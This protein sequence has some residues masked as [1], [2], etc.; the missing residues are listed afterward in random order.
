MALFG[1]STKIAYIGATNG[2]I[3]DGESTKDRIGSITICRQLR[4]ARKKKNIKGII[5][6]LDTP[7]GSATAC[8][9]M[10]CEIKECINASKPVI[11]V[12]SNVAA[13]G[14]Y[15]LSAPCS[16][17]FAS[18]STITGSI[19]IIGI[20]FT[21]KKFWKNKLGVN[22]DRVSTNPL[23]ASFFSQLDG[24][25]EYERIRMEQALTLWYKRFKG[26]ISE[27]RDMEDEKL[28]SVAKGQ[29]WLGT[30][31]LEIGLVDELGG[32][33]DAMK[34]MKE[35]LNIPSYKKIKLVNPLGKM[36]IWDILMGSTPENENDFSVP[37]N[38]FGLVLDMMFNFIRPIT[39]IKRSGMANLLVSNIVSSPI[40]SSVML[41]K[42]GLNNYN[43]NMNSFNYG[44]GQMKWM[45]M[46]NYGCNNNRIFNDLQF[47][48]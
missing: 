4:A 22:Y 23:A 8:H 17:V 18:P 25:G 45:G 7:G 30:Q 35:L 12:Q 19:G 16:Y 13:S 21:T 40:I 38:S 24:F 31:A 32:L 27:P 28:E 9:N 5:L 6:H 42:Y 44:N 3:V 33:Y 29:V 36:T 43:E 2:Q 26:V 37:R 41:M 34:K 47:M 39:W 11:A 1:S 20:K 15:Y 14:G 10:A 48:A 46:M